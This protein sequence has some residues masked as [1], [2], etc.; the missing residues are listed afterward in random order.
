MESFP[1]ETITAF[2]KHTPEK[3]TIEVR[4]CLILCYS[5]EILKPHER[6]SDAYVS[7]H[8]DIVS[9][10]L[11]W[12]DFESSNQKLNHKIGKLFNKANNH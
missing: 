7:M 8:T 3:K 6:E 2:S 5:F 10:S 1:D 9:L 12:Y 4:C 11:V